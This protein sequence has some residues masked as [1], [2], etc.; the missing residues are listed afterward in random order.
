M[1]KKVIELDLCERSLIQL[2]ILEYQDNIHKRLRSI[3][4]MKKRQLKFDTLIDL[5]DLF[6]KIVNLNKE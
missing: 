5:D 1:D 2:A 6:E 4:D 3:K